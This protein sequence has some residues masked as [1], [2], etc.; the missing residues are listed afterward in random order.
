[1]CPEGIALLQDTGRAIAVAA[2]GF[3][4]AGNTHTVRRQW[5]VLWRWSSALRRRGVDAGAGAHV[6]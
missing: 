4:R 1:M 3:R 6:Q 2:K 5:R